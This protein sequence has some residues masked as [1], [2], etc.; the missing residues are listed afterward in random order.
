[1]L[2]PIRA[3]PPEKQQWPD[4]WPSKTTN[5]RA[6]PQWPGPR[7]GSAGR[8]SR[9]GRTDTAVFLPN[10]VRVYCITVPAGAPAGDL[11][12]AAFGSYPL[13]VSRLACP[14]VKVSVL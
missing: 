5:R 7:H 9:W 12:Q 11:L 14:N 3:A 4:R 6:L 10:P 8:P 1:C 2:G 13:L